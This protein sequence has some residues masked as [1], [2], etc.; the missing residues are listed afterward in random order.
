MEAG[1]VFVGSAELELLDDVVA[2]VLGGA[3]GEGGYGAVGEMGAQIIELAVFGAEFVAPFGDAVGFV[4]YEVGDGDFAE[5]FDCG[6]LGYALGREIE[7]AEFA[8]GG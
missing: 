2:D 3:G 6:A 4:D 5:P 1:Y 8:F 7:Q